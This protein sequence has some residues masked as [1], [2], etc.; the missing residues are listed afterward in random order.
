MNHHRRASVLVIIAEILAMLSTLSLA[1]LMRMRQDAQESDLV[2]HLAQC[3]LML[4]TSMQFV[5]ES[6]RLG[7][8]TA[9]DPSVEAW[10]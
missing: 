9:A 10:G 8:A 2:I 7:Y 1:F 3:R 4:H 5:Q 6:S